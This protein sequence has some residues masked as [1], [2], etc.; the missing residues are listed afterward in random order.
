MPNNLMKSK[1]LSGLQCHKRLWNEVRHPDRAAETSISQQRKV[2]THLKDLSR[3]L[4]LLSTRRVSHKQNKHPMPVQQDPLHE[5]MCSK[6]KHS[7]VY[8]AFLFS[9]PVLCLC[10]TSPDL[11]RRTFPWLERN[12]HQC[13]THLYS[14]GGVC[15]AFL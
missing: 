14:G 13:Y 5:K 8:H 4:F 11:H 1:F 3:T 12:S 7:R 2:E 9:L 10:H 15:E 6:S